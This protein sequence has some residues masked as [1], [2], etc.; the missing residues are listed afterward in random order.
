MRRDFQTAPYKD[1][2]R[3]EGLVLALAKIT[4][5][6]LALLLVTVRLHPP[7]LSMASAKWVGRNRMKREE[8][9]EADALPQVAADRHQ[10]SR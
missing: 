9:R 8:A 6:V 3:W 4:E 10:Q 1:M 2:S 5:G 7:S